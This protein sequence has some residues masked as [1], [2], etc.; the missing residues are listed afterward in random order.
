M[1]VHIINALLDT[2]SHIEEWTILETHKELYEDLMQV[3]LSRRIGKAS[4]GSSPS[5]DWG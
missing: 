5:R 4:V 3:H 2:L 1:V